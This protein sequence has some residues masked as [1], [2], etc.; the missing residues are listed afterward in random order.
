MRAAD[1]DAAEREAAA[2]AERKA[3]AK[4]AKPAPRIA[5]RA[6]QAEE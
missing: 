2:Q 4:P 6:G 1:M 5:F 3:A